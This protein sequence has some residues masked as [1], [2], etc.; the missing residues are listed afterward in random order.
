MFFPLADPGAGAPAPLKEVSNRVKYNL[1]V[2]K[3]EEKKFFYL[4]AVTH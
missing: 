4:S 2:I 1:G 3:H